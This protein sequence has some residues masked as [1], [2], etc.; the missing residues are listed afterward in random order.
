MPAAPA[1]TASTPGWRS[2]SESMTLRRASSV[3]PVSP[4]TGVGT[5]IRSRTVPSPMTTPPAILVPPIS[6]PIADL[7]GN[8]AGGAWA[9]ISASRADG[10]HRRLDAEAPG[11]R[12]QRGTF[13]AVS[14]ARRPQ[15]KLAVTECLESHGFPEVLHLPQDAAP[16]AAVFPEHDVGGV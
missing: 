15:D 2:R 16:G 4:V 8:S 11:Q 1:P 3:S 9:V 14:A 6:R 5:S 12:C 13:S 10:Q 7:A